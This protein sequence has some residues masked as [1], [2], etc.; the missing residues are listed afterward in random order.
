MSPCQA[1]YNCVFRTWVLWGFACASKQSSKLSYFIDHPSSPRP[2]P[3]LSSLTILENKKRQKQIT[4]IYWMKTSTCRDGTIKN[5]PNQMGMTPQSFYTIP[6]SCAILPTIHTT[7]LAT[8]TLP[9]SYPHPLNEHSTQ[10]CSLHSLP[11]KD[12]PYPT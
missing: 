3:P 2:L 6:T 11:H 5:Q 1:S 9:Y 7:K 8:C 10:H 4:K 12:N